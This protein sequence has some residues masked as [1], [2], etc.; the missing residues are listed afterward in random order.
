MFH[1]EVRRKRMATKNYHPFLPDYAVHPG[2]TLRDTLKAK[3]MSVKKLSD[4]TRVPRKNLAEI[5]QGKRS[6]DE[7]TAIA[8]SQALGVPAT[9]WL[10]MQVNFTKTTERLARAV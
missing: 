3:R 4:R 9:F 7:G 1:V 5:V 2:E 8:L 6:I 10:N